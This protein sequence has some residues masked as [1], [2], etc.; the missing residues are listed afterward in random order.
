[1]LKNMSDKAR[2]N[3]SSVFGGG[4]VFFINKN[5]KQVSQKLQ[6]QFYGSGEAGKSIL[7]QQNASSAKS[8]ALAL[9]PPKKALPKSTTK[10]SRREEG[11]KN[12]REEKTSAN[13]KV[14]GIRI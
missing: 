6:K 4:A 11:E 1:M 7:F 5:S 2:T 9:L 8:T 12:E 10:K 13:L 14:R 3:G